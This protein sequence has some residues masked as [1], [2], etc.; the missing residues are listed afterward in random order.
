[1]RILRLSLRYTFHKFILMSEIGLFSVKEEKYKE[2][3][4][5]QK[6]VKQEQRKY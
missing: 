3:L 4:L 2:I 1:M 6:S 5:I